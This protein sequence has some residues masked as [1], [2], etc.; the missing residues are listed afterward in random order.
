MAERGPDHS[1]LE[2]GA[3]YAIG[4]TR[5]AIIDL[6][7]NANQPFHDGTG[8]W[9]LTYNGEIYNFRELRADLVELGV[10]FRTQ[11]DTEVL[12]E[13][14][15][16]YGVEPTLTRLRGMFAF[17]LRDGL[18]GRVIAA[19]DHLGQKPL[20]Y[21]AESG[22]V[23]LASDI[24]ALLALKPSCAPD[25]SAWP[26]YMASFG[27]LQ[28]D[29]T[30]F[31]GISALAA[32][33][34]LEIVDTVVTV[35]R[36]FAAWQLFDRN[37]YAAALRQ[38]D[39]EAIE[40]LEVNLTRAVE[41]HLVSDV[42]VG[43]CLSGGIDS[44]LVFWYTGDRSRQLTAFTKLS[45]GIE[46]IPM[47]VVP[48]L[49][50]DRPASAYFQLEAPD[51][52]IAR[53]VEFVGASQYPSRWGGG[54]PMTRLCRAARQLKTLVLL[55][56]DG[57]DEYAAGYRTLEPL[58]DGFDGDQM[59][60]HSI[61]DVSDAAVEAGRPEC[62]AFRKF[63]RGVRREIL[64]HIGDLGDDKEAFMQATLLHDTSSFLQ[65]CNLP[66]SDAYS[67]AAS[68]ELRNPLLDLDLVRYVVNQPM[69]RKFGAAASGYRNKLLFRALAQQRMGDYVNVEKE[70]TR[71]YSM[72]V[73][74]LRYWNLANFAIG[75]IKPLPAA[76][77][78][79]ELFKLVNLEIHHR[80]FFAKESGFLPRLLTT[81]GCETILS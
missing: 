35:R 79:K 1:S 18:T 65:S 45:P 76:P 58:F 68:V 9:S 75:K 7:A 27:I 44:S 54:P 13:C 64:D 47:S 41:R 70:G 37:D 28:P 52:Y 74:Q 15:L 8:R 57:V 53:L 20:Y 69:R 48:Q 10:E 14:L 51:S 63:Q 46:T 33:H 61:V 11:S 12:L 22:L 36:Y 67:M 23:A 21:F 3:N 78:P 16:R 19:R 39:A 5:L 4:H 40:G 71:N 43:V 29:R 59:K 72:A 60:L 26:V 24:R 2:V 81:E 17:I 32:G 25:L 66:H 30:F 31:Q 73:S 62:Q 77:G 6:S 50:S 55:G 34:F 80:I 42:P 38:S 49:L 56:G